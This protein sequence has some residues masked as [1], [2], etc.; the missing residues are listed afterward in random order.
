MGHFRLA[1]SK[2]SLPSKMFPDEV[3]RWEVWRRWEVLHVALL[4][5][6]FMSRS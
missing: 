1:D 4:L 2:L 3:W 5:F 6:M